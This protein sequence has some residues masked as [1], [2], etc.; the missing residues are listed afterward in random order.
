MLLGQTAELGD[1]VLSLEVEHSRLLFVDVPEGIDTD[2][3]HTQ[4]LAH[5]NAV[6]PVFGGN[7]R[8][9]HLGGFDE[10]GFPVEQELLV[11][12]GELMGFTFLGT[13]PGDA[14][15]RAGQQAGREEILDF[16]VFGYV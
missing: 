8:V 4:S 13:A 2:G 16:H 7:T 6:F 3:V 14:Q 15:Q 5:L 1:V 10:E 12:N 9:V 11:A